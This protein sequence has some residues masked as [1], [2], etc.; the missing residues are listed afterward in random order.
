LFMLASPALSETTTFV[1]TFDDLTE[2]EDEEVSFSSYGPLYWSN[3]TVQHFPLPSWEPPSGE[4]FG[5]LGTFEGSAAE[6]NISDGHVTFESGWFRMGGSNIL[7]IVT[8]P[9]YGELTIQ[10]FTSSGPSHWEYIEPASTFN[11]SVQIYGC[12]PDDVTGTCISDF[13]PVVVD[14]LTF[15]IIN[16]DGDANDDGVVDLS[17]LNGVRNEFGAL[18]PGYDAN[19]DGV[20]DVGDLNS[21]RNNFGISTQ[22]PEPS[23]IVIALVA[24]A[25]AFRT[26][27]RGTRTGSLDSRTD[28]CRAR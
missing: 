2:I 26:V 9:I 3:S 1:A 22:V 17:D 14:D 25:T 20:S 12:R 18:E 11:R 10:E 23:S 19:D 21:V 15:T 6:L 4:Y 13:L 27:R 7:R 8:F 24:I 28:R 5:R 16:Q